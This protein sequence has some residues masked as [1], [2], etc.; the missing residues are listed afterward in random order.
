MVPAT[1]AGIGVT[2]TI[3][4]AVPVLPLPSVTVQVTVV[5]PAGNVAGAL[6]VTLA[7]EQLSAVAGVPKLTPVP[8]HVLIVSDA[9]FNGVALI[10][11]GLK[12]ATNWPPST[13]SAVLVAGA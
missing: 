10:D 4:V 11:A 5:F 8:E 3:C 13:T 2:I 12:N 7:T 9:A 1:G 6:L